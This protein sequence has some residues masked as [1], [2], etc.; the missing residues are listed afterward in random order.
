MVITR[1]VTL[2]I[3]LAGLAA[4]AIPG[5]A[6]AARVEELRNAFVAGAAVRGDGITLTVPEIAENGAS[7][8]VSIEAPGAVTILLLASG[9]PEPAVAT[10]SFGPLAGRH[11]VDTRIRLAQSQNVVALARMPDGSVLETRAQVQVTVGGCVG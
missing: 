5:A 4:L 8:P 2:R 11:L 6:A 7:V 9:N 1:R 10:V 3:G